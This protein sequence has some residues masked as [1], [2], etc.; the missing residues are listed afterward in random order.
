MT[1]EMLRQ[2][3]IGTV[4]TDRTDWF[5]LLETPHSVMIL[6]EIPAPK[7]DQKDF[8]FGL[9]TLCFASPMSEGRK[10]LAPVVVTQT[11]QKD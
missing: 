10:Q 8:S 1:A 5:A 7:T 4:Q 3:V 2:L 9:A 6:Q 11:D